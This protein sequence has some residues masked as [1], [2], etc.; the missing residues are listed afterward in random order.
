MKYPYK[1]GCNILVKNTCVWGDVFTLCL[2]RCVHTVFG[3]ML[4]HCVWG[5]VFTLCLGR[6]FH[7]AFGAMFSHCV[8][9]DAF[10]LCLGRCFRTVLGRCFHT[11]CGAMFQ[12]ISCGIS[13]SVGVFFVEWLDVFDEA[14]DVTAWVGSLNT[15][16][17]FAIGKFI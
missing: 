11:V 2:G 5:D 1:D 17:M 3:A 13:F 9:G 16:L 10:T 8:W 6:C 7:T 12:G 4:S 14:H 15:G